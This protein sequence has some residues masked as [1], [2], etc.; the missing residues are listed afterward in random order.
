MDRVKLTNLAIKYYSDKKLCH[1]MRV[2][3]YASDNPFADEDDRESLW[4]IGLAHDLIEDTKCPEEELISCLDTWEYEAVL[5][6]THHKEDC[7]Y[8]EY[9]KIL[10][11]SDN[12]FV[13]AV[14]RADMKDHLM[15]TDTLTDKLKNKYYPTV[16]YI[17]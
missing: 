10:A 4:A 8:E 9:M 7:S 13:L 3:S 1:A 5:Q 12:P 16:K 14:K 6:L 17:L 11:T 2:A 15:L